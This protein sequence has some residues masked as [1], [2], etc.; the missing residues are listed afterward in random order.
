MKRKFP[1]KYHVL[2]APEDMMIIMSKRGMIIP[3]DMLGGPKKG[4]SRQF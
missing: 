3:L 4:T 2:T 1:S